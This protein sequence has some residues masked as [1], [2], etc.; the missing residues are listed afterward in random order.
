MDG[1]YDGDK[2]RQLTR[3]LEMTPVVP[4]KASRR[5]PWIL[6][7]KFTRYGTKSNGCLDRLKHWSCLYVRDNKFDE[8]GASQ[9]FGQTGCRW[10]KA[11]AN[12]LLAIKCCIENNRWTNFLIGGFVAA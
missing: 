12:A 11:D 9:I 10:L 4:L 7:A 3:D 1:A 2:T 5:Y 6:T 8:I